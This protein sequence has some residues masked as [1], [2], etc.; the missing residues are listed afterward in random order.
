M[1]TASCSTL[2]C[3]IRSKT[4]I[5]F[6]SWE[7]SSPFAA[8]LKILSGMGWCVW[9][10]VRVYKAS[11]RR[12]LYDEI[13]NAWVKKDR[14]KEFGICVSGEGCGCWISAFW[15]TLMI[16]TLV[17]CTYGLGSV[18]VVCLLIITLVDYSKY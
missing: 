13:V 5:L 1:S 17:G 16:H 15:K 14:N 11:S 7:S 3:N 6:Q 4:R 18:E 2:Q 9:S 12:S 10:S 8:Y